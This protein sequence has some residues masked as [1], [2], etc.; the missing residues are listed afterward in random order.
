M[1]A[2]IL[3]T[4]FLFSNLMISAPETLIS[5]SEINLIKGFWQ[6]EIP[7]EVPETQI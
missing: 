4:A 1:K 2:L 5:S 6:K 7:R 3:I